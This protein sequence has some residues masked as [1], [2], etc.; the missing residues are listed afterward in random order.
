ME[1]RKSEKSIVGS[2]EEKCKKRSF[3]KISNS[4]VAQKIT[5]SKL[6]DSTA[7]FQSKCEAFIWPSYKKKGIPALYLTIS[8]KNFVHITPN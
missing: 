1:K 6:W 3:S 7:V 4:N 8:L 5:A 2:S